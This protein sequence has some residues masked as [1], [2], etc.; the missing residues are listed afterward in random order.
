MSSTIVSINHRVCTS[1]ASNFLEPLRSK[2]LGAY[3]ESGENLWAN[4]QPQQSGL[5]DGPFID[6]VGFLKGAVKIPESVSGMPTPCQADQP[7]VRE[8][9]QCPKCPNFNRIQ[10]PTNHQD[11]WK[12]KGRNISLR[13]CVFGR[14]PL[15]STSRTKHV[16]VGFFASQKAN[17][18]VL[19]CKMAILKWWWRH[20]VP[21]LRP[22]HCAFGEAWGEALTCWLTAINQD[23]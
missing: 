4:A 19:R 21:Q 5:W 11:M 18:Q 13:S 3:S 2:C 1:N 7:A 17:S 16:T 22:R 10:K 6:K 14:V 15:T 23:Q 8:N 20:D 12:A 9:V